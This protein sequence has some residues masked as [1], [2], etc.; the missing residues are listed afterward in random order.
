[1]RLRGILC[2]LVGLVVL[3][4]APAGAFAANACPNEALREAQGS[5]FL[6]DCRAY[7]LVSPV[8]KRGVDVSPAPSR[9]RASSDGSAVQYTALGG[10]A[11]AIGTNA[12]GAEYIAERGA[13]GWS[14]HGITPEQ[15]PPPIPT[16]SSRYTGDFSGDLSK[17]VFFALSPLTSEPNVANV[18]NLYLRNDLLSPGG[19]SYQLLTG[20]A[21]CESP[22]SARP[23]STQVA[24]PAFAG[25]SSDFSHVIFE[26]PENLT[27][28]ASGGGVKLYESVNG[29][30]R[31]AGILPDSACGSSPCPAEESIAGAGALAYA[32]EYLG[33]STLNTISADGSR[34]VFEAGPF[35]ANPQLGNL[36]MRENGSTTVRLNAS[37]RSPATQPQPALFSAAT[38]DDSKVFFSTTEALTENAPDDN[39]EKLYMYDVNAPAKH[40]LTL[41]SH[42]NT[43]YASGIFALGTSEDGSYVYFYGNYPLIAGQATVEAH[44]QLYVWHDGA[45]RYIGAG[46][47]PGGDDEANW[48]ENTIN[49]NVSQAR[50]S[51]NGKVVVFVTTARRMAEAVGYDNTGV[52]GSSCAPPNEHDGCREV[53]VYDYD[54]NRVTCVSCDSSGARPT[55]PAEIAVGTNDPTKVTITWHLNRAVTDDGSE[56]FFDSPDALVPQDTNGK[57]DVYEYDVASGGLHLISSGQSSQDSLLVE[58]S[59]SGR[60]VFFTTRQQLVRADVDGNTDIYDARVAGGI[61]VQDAAPVASC[62]GDGCQGSLAVAPT[63]ASPP[64]MGVFGAGNLAPRPLLPQTKEKPKKKRRRR[65]GKVKRRRAAKSTSRRAGR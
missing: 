48:G 37:E 38:P 55:G 41:I 44:N 46:N 31:L 39:D 19:G 15:T 17:G 64:S 23:F 3:G 59:S 4:L 9:T 26:S 47:Q 24:D 28:D 12:I 60:D 63:L 36:Y 57:V 29:A 56:V 7:E 40:H 27:P 65:A 32:H 22:L 8:D 10:F 5:T 62:L 11:D 6:G 51:T 2:V 34:I 30:V 42:D 61:A 45:L 43:P 53:Y 1:M 35:S 14:S 50:V 18:R 54:T 13:G 20:C 58:A 25:A 16:W 49:G 21:A 33:V 52:P